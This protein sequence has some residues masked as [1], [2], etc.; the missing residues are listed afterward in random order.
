MKPFIGQ[1]ILEI[2]GAGTFREHLQNNERSV[3]HAQFSDLHTTVG[4]M[5]FDTVICPSGLED[6]GNDFAALSAI[7]SV[8]EAGGRLVLAVPAFNH[9]RSYSKKTLVPKMRSAG[10]RIENAFYM[11]AIGMAGIDLLDAYV[12]GLADRVERAIPLPF[13]VSLIAVGRRPRY[14][15][16]QTGQIAR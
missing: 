5:A 15:L 16:F 1:R 2:G 3:A 7:F 9:H 14:S 6:T 4:N 12:A 11:D 8:L 13:G 10:F